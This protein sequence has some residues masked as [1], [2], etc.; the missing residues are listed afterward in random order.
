[1]ADILK[2][3][4][5]AIDRNNALHQ[6]KQ[7]A[8][9]QV[10]FQMTETAKVVKTNPQSELLQQ[11]NGADKQEA[12]AILMNML[13]DPGVAVNFLKN[14][15]LLQEIINLIPVNNQALTSEINQL[16]S[17]LMVKPEDIAGEL[18]SQE[19][20]A[21]LF[22]GELFD[23]LRNLLQENNRPEMR[24]ATAN[25]LKSMNA[26]LS[27]ENVLSSV[28]N[29]L[30]FLAES[31]HP[32][33]ELSARLEQLVQAFRGNDAPEK[34]P[35][36]KNETLALMRDV[37][38]SILFTPKMEKLVPM[39][40]YNLSRFS[41]NPDYFDDAARA[42]MNMMESPEQKAEFLQKL[43][44]FITQLPAHIRSGGRGDQVS[45]EAQQQE[46]RVMDALVKLIGRQALESDPTTAEAEKLD[47]IINSLLS[48]PCNFTPLLH[49][50]I[51][52]EDNN[53]RSFAEIWIENSDGESGQRQE[54]GEPPIHLLAVFDIGGIGRFEAELFV[55]GKSL[56]LNLLCPESHLDSF[57]EMRDYAARLAAGTS[58]TL[59]EMYIGKLERSRSLMDVFKTLPRKRAGIDVKI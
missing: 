45:A 33:K 8:E 37:E 35:Q 51:P 3:N 49:F 55:N 52:V 20:S 38:N 31:L 22:K 29:N 26:A 6:T 15:T 12:P 25:L 48:S 36:L 30:K 28:S 58:Y 1:M 57:M 46:S 54:D 5:P 10:P 59:K 53:I 11:N 40:T 32:S 56:G 24:F 18:A 21:T 47:K 4:M 9:A 17:Q 7:L 13:R 43:K 16:F 2:V 14:I 39:I 42:L 23:M 50:I 19:N 34:F 44:D 41:D 27:K